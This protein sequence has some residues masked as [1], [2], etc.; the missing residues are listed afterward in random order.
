MLIESPSTPINKMY[1]R[2]PARTHANTTYVFPRGDH[3]GVILGGCR[4]DNVWEGEPDMD[5]AEDIK[6]RCVALC[7]GLG[8]VEDLKVIKHGVG[9]RR[10]R[11]KHWAFWGK[12]LNIL[13]ID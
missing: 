9:L 7:P 6:R 13:T 12:S 3:G 8:K 4:R 1:F 5:F 2:S 10:K 11:L